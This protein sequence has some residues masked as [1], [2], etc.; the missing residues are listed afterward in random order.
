ML[1]YEE[2][3][4]FDDFYA[5]C[6][7]S[8][9]LT[10]ITVFFESI[11]CYTILFCLLRMKPDPVPDIYAWDRTEPWFVMG[12]I[13]FIKVDALYYCM[14]LIICIFSSLQLK[15]ITMQNHGVRTKESKIPEHIIRDGFYAKKRHPM[16]G[17][18][19]FLYMGVLLSLR[20]INGILLALLLIGIQYIN[21]MWEEKRILQTDLKEEYGAYQ[22]NVHSILFDRKQSIIVILLFLGCAI[23]FFY[24]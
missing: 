23:G 11:I 15:R 6:Q 19:S 12:G 13:T 9:C 8:R 17:T 10:F 16:Y 21:A 20:S 14:G 18:F 7:K 2:M 3:L 1:K 24:N 22:K 5:K 4:H